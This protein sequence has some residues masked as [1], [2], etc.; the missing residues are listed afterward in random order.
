MYYYA[1]MHNGSDT[2]YVQ[3]WTFRVFEKKS[4]GWASLQVIR[5]DDLEDDIVEIH[6]LED[7]MICKAR[8][9][10]IDGVS[11]FLLNMPNV[12]KGLRIALTPSPEIVPLTLSNIKTVIFYGKGL[13]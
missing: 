7:E 9:K 2:N 1:D 8:S 5:I 12:E 6:D 3:R 10:I 13:P 4:K 11:T